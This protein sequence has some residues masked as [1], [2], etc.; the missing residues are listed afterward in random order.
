MTDTENPTTLVVLS[1]LWPK[2]DPG[3]Y[4]TA[5]VLVTHN[6]SARWYDGERCEFCGDPGVDE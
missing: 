4:C 1:R 5:Q 3:E 6:H 2:R